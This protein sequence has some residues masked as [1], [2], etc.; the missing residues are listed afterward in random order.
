M[1]RTPRRKNRFR[2]AR[3][4]GKDAAL[5]GKTALTN[6][7]SVI[8]PDHDRWLDGFLSVWSADQANGTPEEPEVIPIEKNDR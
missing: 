2:S 6:P 1:S 5:A 4:D 8:D 7:Y 3:R